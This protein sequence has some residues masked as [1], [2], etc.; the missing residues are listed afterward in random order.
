MKQSEIMQVATLLTKMLSQPCTRPS[1]DSGFDS[2]M[3]ASRSDSHAGS[4]EL[5]CAWLCE[6]KCAE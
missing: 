5:V 4:A 1:K 3:A 2:C 6:Q